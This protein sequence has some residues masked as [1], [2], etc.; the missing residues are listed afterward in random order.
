MSSLEI[1]AS[2]GQKKSRFLSSR[3]SRFNIRTSR[4]LFFLQD[5]LIDDFDFNRDQRRYR[6][7]LEVSVDGFDS[8][9]ADNLRI[10]NNVSFQGAV[11]QNSSASLGNGVKAH[12]H[13][14]FAPRRFDR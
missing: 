11:A 1:V 14:P 10:L 12:H 5:R 4:L 9:L 2:A 8:R 3:H 7:T 13:D 6:F